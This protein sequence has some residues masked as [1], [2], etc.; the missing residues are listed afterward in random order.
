MVDEAKM[1]YSDN[2]AIVETFIENVL[3]KLRT[4]HEGDEEWTERI[5]EVE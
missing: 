2:E 4:E 5:N 1:K 3:S